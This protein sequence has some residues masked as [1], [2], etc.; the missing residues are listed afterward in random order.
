[1]QILMN[2]G[3]HND[4]DGRLLRHAESVIQTA[5]ERFSERITRVEVHLNDENSDAKSGAEDKRCLLEVRV[6]GLEP[7]VT[8]D[9]SDT[10]DSAI[11]GA[12][13]KMKRLLESTFSKLAMT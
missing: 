3:S 10:F 6:A 11:H 2:A 7:V 12:A 9:Q 1:M 8:S 4:V 5:L 13:H